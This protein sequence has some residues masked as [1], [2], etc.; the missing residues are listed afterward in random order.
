MN[1]MRFERQ[2]G[3]GVRRQL[4]QTQAELRDLQGDIRSI[5]KAFEV[6]EASDAVELVSSAVEALGALG[7]AAAKE[8]DGGGFALQAVTAL[9]AAQLQLESAEL[10]IDV[11]GLPDVSSEAFDGLVVE[12]PFKMQGFSYRQLVKPDLKG[13]VGKLKAALAKVWHLVSRLVT[14]REWKVSGEVAGGIPG[15]GLAKAGIEI[16]FG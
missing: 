3:P 16:T 6:P 1:G 12:T 5:A 11:H 8:V 9:N 10:Q 7:A 15:I 4:T 14:P 2:E 13:V